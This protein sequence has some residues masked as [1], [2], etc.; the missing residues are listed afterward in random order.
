MLPLPEGL[1]EAERQL[2]LGGIKCGYFAP[3]ASSH[4]TP[5]YNPKAHAALRDTCRNALTH[6]PD[7]PP[8]L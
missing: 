2:Y 8:S 3:I 7:P 4:F 6:L 1:N 5:L